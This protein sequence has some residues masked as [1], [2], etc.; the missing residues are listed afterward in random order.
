V[1]DGA[2]KPASSGVDMVT[3]TPT[4]VKAS[5]RMFSRWPGLCIQA[6]TASAGELFARS[7]RTMFSPTMALPAG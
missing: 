1:A 3:P 7:P 4:S 2:S 5:R 6:S